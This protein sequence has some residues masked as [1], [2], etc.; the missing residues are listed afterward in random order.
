MGFTK[1]P[2]LPP[3]LVRSYRTVSP[4][5]DPRRAIGGLFSVALSS[6]SPRRTLARI[7]LVGAPTFLTGTPARLP[8]RLTVR[9]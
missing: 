6:G 8:S 4:L 5:P 2:E 1:P 7:L 9:S 3:V